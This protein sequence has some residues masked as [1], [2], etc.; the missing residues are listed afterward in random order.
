MF[1]NNI[2]FQIQMHHVYLSTA[3]S[4]AQQYLV[5]LSIR[6]PWFLLVCAVLSSVATF[7]G[8]GLG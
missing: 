5:H 3:V 8:V 6:L 1:Y 7:L 2:S 4:Y